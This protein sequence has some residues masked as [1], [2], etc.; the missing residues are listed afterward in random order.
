[1]TAIKAIQEQGGNHARIVIVVECCEESGSPDLPH[2]IE[3]LKPRLGVPDLIVCLDSGCGTY[4]QFWVTTSLRG[5]IGGTLKV[6]VM[7]QACHSG[8]GSGVYPSSFRILR[9]LLSRIEDEATGEM[10]LPELFAQIPEERTNQAKACAQVLPNFFEEYN[11]VKGLAPVTK[12]IQQ[13]MLNRTWRPAL[14]VTVRKMPFNN[15]EGR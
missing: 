8:I 1:V 10:K 14:S 15:H 4:D 11:I 5:L 7:E 6:Q 3:H 9:S 12:D 13:A 2:Y